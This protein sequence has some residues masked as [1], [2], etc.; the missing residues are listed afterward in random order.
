MPLD[1]R[2]FRLVVDMEVGPGIAG[3]GFEGGSKFAAGGVG[4]DGVGACGV[5]RVGGPVC[6]VLGDKALNERL[7]GGKVGD[8]DIGEM[9]LPRTLPE[10]EVHGAGA[11]I[12][13]GSELKCDGLG[14][15]AQAIC[16]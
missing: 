6:P 11:G 2:Q 9:N 13:G 16:R 5:R 8:G 4:V 3:R 12:A 10:T 7:A 1:D 14:L 15:G